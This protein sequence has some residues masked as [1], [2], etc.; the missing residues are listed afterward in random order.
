VVAGYRAELQSIED[1]IRQLGEKALDPPIDVENATKYVYR[2]YQRASLTDNLEELPAVERA[3][4]RLIPQL[5]HADDL[6]LLKANVAFKVHRLDDVKRNLDAAPGLRDTA[7]GMK[8]EAD[9][10]FQEGRYGEAEAAYTRAIELDRSWDNLA[11]YA[12]FIG[13][14]KSV[15]EAD[16]LYAEAEDELTS[17]Q[18]RSYAWVELQRAALDVSRGDYEAA[19]AHHGRA[20][21][22]YAGYWMTDQRAAAL[23][24]AEGRYD[25]AAAAYEQVL[26]VVSKPELLQKAGELYVRMG[27]PDRAESYL[28]TALAK[29]SESANRGE[30]HYYH[31]L[32]DYHC[33]VTE[34]YAEAARWA[35]M[36]LALRDNFST[37]SALAWALF[38]SGESRE[39]LE[40][41][42]RALDSGVIEPRIHT[43]AAQIQAACL[44]RSL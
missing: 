26:P 29:F 23:L 33:R 41:I 35:R 37:R 30:V 40:H 24:A 43:Q 13:K 11:R 5:R 27:E 2:L 3:I 34:D 32:V 44:Q 39:A 36:D 6:Y 9:L 7:E 28:A 4:D 15:D 19:R 31:H 16:R 17:K 8:L 18:M 21:A 42:Q 25:E 14:M 38:R 1:E 10:H 20:K 22:A 12:H